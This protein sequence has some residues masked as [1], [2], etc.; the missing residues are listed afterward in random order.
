ME[1]LCVVTG[2]PLHGDPGPHLPVGA[3]QGLAAELVFPLNL[4]L[5]ISLKANSCLVLTLLP[6]PGMEAAEACGNGKIEGLYPS[7]EV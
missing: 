6:N 3:E 4:S 2:V 7:L 1:L 5:T